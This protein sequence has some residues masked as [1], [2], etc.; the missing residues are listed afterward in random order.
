MAA[1]NV[2]TTFKFNYLLSFQ[3]LLHSCGDIS[4]VL[5]QMHMPRKIRSVLLCM[6]AHNISDPPWWH[7]LYAFLLVSNMASTTKT[8][9]ENWRIASFGNVENGCFS[10]LGTQQM[11]QG[12]MK[13]RSL[14]GA[15]TS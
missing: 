2:Y 10:S 8:D 6:H 5:L 1:G 7:N 3:R 4:F 13:P 9:I 12:R 11:N 15:W 14:H